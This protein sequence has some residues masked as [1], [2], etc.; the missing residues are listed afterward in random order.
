M[1]CGM[2]RE[3]FINTTHGT[4]LFHIVVD[5]LIRNHRE[6]FIRVR[7]RVVSIFLDQ[8]KGNFH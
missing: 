2:K 6:Y 1:S 5:L 8:T 3:F 7:F 4:D